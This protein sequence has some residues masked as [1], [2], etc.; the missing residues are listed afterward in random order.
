MKS[1]GFTGI[2]K[3]LYVKWSSDRVSLLAGALAYNCLFALAPL[4]LI[5]ISAVR[6]LLGPK[7]SRG[8]IAEALASYVGN[9]NA[10]TLQNMIQVLH[11]QWGH[12]AAASTLCV[13]TLILA[14]YGLFSA[15]R[16]GLNTIWQVHPASDSLGQMVKT[17]IF[18]ILLL[19]CW[20]LILLASM[21]F[22]S[23]LNVYCQ[24]TNVGDFIFPAL[25]IIADV[26]VFFL[27]TA[28]IFKFIPAAKVRWA[29]I[30]LGSLVTAVLFVA[31][32]FAINIYLNRVAL[33]SA[34][35]AASSVIILLLW[36]YYS[37]QILFLGAEF[38]HICAARRKAK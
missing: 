27:L 28:V 17:G 20:T 24:R 23:V 1:S 22:S 19:L 36:I 37:A 13:L 14:I 12:G 34:Y 8:Q 6:L 38:T 35:A 18:W 33:S 10:K 21:A 16:G 31:G 15:L 29:D 2:A 3:E 25:K 11:H 5:L 9:E 32:E 4:L 7:A 26:F 30:W